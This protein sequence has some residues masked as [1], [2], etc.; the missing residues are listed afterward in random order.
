M[1]SLPSELIFCYNLVYVVSSFP[2]GILADR[3]GL[4]KIIIFGVIIFAGVY[5]SMAINK[6]LY[7]YFLLFLLYGIYA[8][9][10]GGIAKAWISN[11]TDAESTT[12]YWHIQ[13]FSKYR[14]MLASSIAGI[15]C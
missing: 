2:T 5:A 15:L 9:S 3:I 1:I 6:N 4:R 14:T 7:V 8:D 11:I 13:K 10:T 12:S